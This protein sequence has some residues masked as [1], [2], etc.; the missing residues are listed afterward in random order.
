[1]NLSKAILACRELDMLE[2]FKYFKIDFPDHVSHI[3]C[4][5]P[6]HGATGNTPSFSF[7]KDTNSFY[8]WGCKVAGDNI[9]FVMNIL[10]IDFR[11]AVK[12]LV[13]KF[14]IKVESSLLVKVTG[15]AAYKESAVDETFE[16]IDS[17]VSLRE[18]TT[19][20]AD[21]IQAVMHLYQKF[22]KAPNGKRRSNTR[23]P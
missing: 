19:S 18:R 9:S 1:M 23:Q 8:C 11:E 2:V 16:I 6:A 5:F 7:Y 3:K 22:L 15:R 10:D 4:P 14:D 13:S 21:R 12:F 20:L 17:I